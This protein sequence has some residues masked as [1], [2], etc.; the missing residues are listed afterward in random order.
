MFPEI[1]PACASSRRPTGTRVAATDFVTIFVSEN[2]LENWRRRLSTL[3]E[4]ELGVEVDAEASAG[5]L[6]TLSETVA[7][8]AD[9]ASDAAQCREPEIAAQ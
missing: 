9:T 6:L 8:K 4:H 1:G 3:S 2:C 5:S 7:A